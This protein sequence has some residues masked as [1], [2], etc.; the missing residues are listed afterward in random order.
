MFNKLMLAALF[1]LAACQLSANEEAS[2]K[3]NKI[4][5]YQMAIDQDRDIYILDTETG[6]VKRVQRGTFM[7]FYATEFAGWATPELI[8]APLE[9][10]E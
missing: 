8:V 7:G 1:C 4:G 10:N 6:A 3:E 9:N 2:R 5:K